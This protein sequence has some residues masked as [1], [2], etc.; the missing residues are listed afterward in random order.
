MN[1]IVSRHESSPGGCA[2]GLDVRV[3][4]DHAVSGQ[5]VKVGGEDG[6]VCPR[7]VIVTYCDS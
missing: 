7:D 5:G 2:D 3:V 6:G 1:R 4:Q